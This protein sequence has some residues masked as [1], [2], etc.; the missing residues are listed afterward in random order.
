MMEGSSDAFSSVGDVAVNLRPELLKIELLIEVMQGAAAGLHDVSL[1][2][3][4]P[5]IT[6]QL[7]T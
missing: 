1:K 3:P 7:P 4:L 5:L 6:V 2:S